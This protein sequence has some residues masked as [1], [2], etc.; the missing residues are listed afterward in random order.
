MIGN[1]RNTNLSRDYQSVKT[2]SNF[3]DCTGG[4][5]TG[6]STDNP[7]HNENKKIERI[8]TRFNHMHANIMEDEGVNFNDSKGRY[9]K[10]SK[11]KT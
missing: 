2:R 3:E 4:E 7:N 1:K 5:D 11:K 8:C 6:K 9:V 10:S